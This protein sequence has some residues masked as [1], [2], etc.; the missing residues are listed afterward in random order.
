MIL[1][2]SSPNLLLIN[3]KV[4]LSLGRLLGSIRDVEYDHAEYV[5]YNF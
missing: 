4:L 2:Q 3:S 5:L 1:P